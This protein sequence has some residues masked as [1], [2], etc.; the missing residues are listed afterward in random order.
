MTGGNPAFEAPL[1]RAVA[2]AGAA[3]GAVYIIEGQD[4]NPQSTN[5]EIRSIIVC[6]GP[7]QT[8]SAK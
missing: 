4:A 2:R 6:F 5:E 7:G 3:D 8:M 1:F